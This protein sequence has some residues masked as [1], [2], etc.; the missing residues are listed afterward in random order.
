MPRPTHTPD[1]ASDANYPAGSD[2]WSSQPTKV[3][4]DP[5]DETQGFVPATRPPAQW[6]NWILN[7]LS[8]W[9]VYLTDERDRLAG[10]IGGDAG[11]GEWAYPTARERT[12]EIDLINGVT[13]TSGG[14]A[15]DLA[16]GYPR[17]VSVS[18][19]AEMVIPLSPYLRSGMEITRVDVRVDPGTGR[20][21]AGDRTTF[22]VIY[23]APT[24]PSGAIGA[25]SLD[26]ETTDDTGSVQTVQL[27]PTA[28]ATVD[29][30]TRSYFLKI[31]AGDDGG[32]H[33]P[34]VLQGVRLVVND[35]GP[36][37]Y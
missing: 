8:A 21:T 25:G 31:T 36:R 33:A 5:S 26:A 13:V 4:P 9:V 34:D 10:Y 3:Q 22:E 27:V 12:I 17:W 32:I 23:M 14:W 30:S 6:W 2:P 37:N 1:W 28:F 19:D 18:D 7:L 11:T 20:T 15:M 35:P 24:Y 29:R 16:G